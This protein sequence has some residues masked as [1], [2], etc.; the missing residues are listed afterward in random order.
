MG[1]GGGEMIVTPSLAGERGAWTEPTG[2]LRIVKAL[3]TN[4]A[5]W[6]VVVAIG[7]GIYLWLAAS[8]DLTDASVYVAGGRAIVGHLALYDVR[9]PGSGLPFTYPPF[10]ALLFTPLTLLP[11]R[12]TQV[13]W[14][15]ASLALLYVVVR[16]CVERFAGLEWSG[17]ARWILV[18]CLACD[19]VRVTLAVGQINGFIAFLVLEDLTAP[20]ARLRG[21]RIGVAA[22]IKLTPLYLLGYLLAT[23]RWR[24]ALTSMVAFVAA[25]LLALVIDRGDSLRYWSG[26]FL[27]AGRVGRIHYASNQSLYAMLFRW[28]GDLHQ[29]QILWLVAA[30]ALSLAFL[31]LVWRTTRSWGSWGSWGFWESGEPKADE[32]DLVAMALAL[33]LLCSPISWAHH[34]ILAIPLVLVGIRRAVEWGT[35]V[36]AVAPVALAAALMIGTIWLVPRGG[37]AELDYRPPAFIIGNSYV[38]LALSAIVTAAVGVLR[39]PVTLSICP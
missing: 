9:T 30:G 21:A 18:L 33:G 32:L 17:P 23:R 11:L 14:T 4:D 13:A 39:R 2:R 29:T 7:C 31:V 24:A 3:L 28:V 16:R 38:L 1:Y 19:P 20:A 26:V 5:L 6:L 12:A 22:A 25:G 10:A 27:D 34:W 35:P 37:T 15:A 36:W 8:R